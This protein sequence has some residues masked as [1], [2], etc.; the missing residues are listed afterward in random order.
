MT[1]TTRRSQA[2]LTVG[3]FVAGLAA[4]WALHSAQR[5]DVLGF[6]AA[7]SGFICALI[8]VM[9]GIAGIIVI[10]IDEAGE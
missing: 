10:A 9:C 7:V 6:G 1:I 3:V 4:A 5:G 8:L 2:L